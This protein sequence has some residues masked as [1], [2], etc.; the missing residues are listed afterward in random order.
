MPTTGLGLGRLHREHGTGGVGQPGPV[1]VLQ[2]L[3][4]RFEVPG[5][6]AF[7]GP[8]YYHFGLSAALPFFIAVENTLGSDPSF[9]ETCI[10]R[11]DVDPW[12]GH[13][14]VEGAEVTFDNP[15]RNPL[16]AATQRWSVSIRLPWG[17]RPPLADARFDSANGG[18]VLA[19]FLGDTW[20]EWD[21]QTNLS[22]PTKTSGGMD[23][24]PWYLAYANEDAAE[25]PDVTTVFLPDAGNAVFRSDWSSEA[26][27]G[28]LVA[29]HGDARKTL[30]DHVDGTSFTLAAYGEYLLLDPGYYKPNE[31]DNAIT[32]HG[33]AHNLILIDGQG[34]PNKGLLTD[35][36]D[37]DA[38][39][40]DFE[41]TD[42]LDYAEARIAY[43]GHDIVRGVALVRDSWFVI[44]DR[45]EG[46]GTHEYTFR[47]N[48]YAGH[49]DIGGAF[50]LNE[51]GA[52]WERTAAGVRVYVSAPGVVFQ[53]P[54]FNE[55]QRPHVH[56]F[57]N[58]DPRHHTVMDAVATG[59]AVDFLTVAVPYRVGDTPWTVTAIDGG[60]QV[61]DDTVTL[62]D[63]TLVITGP[64]G[65]LLRD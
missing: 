36:G 56:E 12:T 20:A 47:L 35:F 24:A 23:L 19:A 7:E 13:G 50:T 16:L 4:I 8:L 45:L 53:E 31:L 27:W 51:D 58:N 34:P 21:W 29:E 15:L 64:E 60:W 28:L 26:V 43:E 46:S 9:S 30:H 32:A 5:V 17:P 59:E 61:G 25:A 38:W 62:V 37:T 10:N 49:E 6:Q 57:E 39:L 65:E 44:A 33:D 22:A 41:Q 63:G 14:C 40:E 3:D 18:P 54:P 1:V 55:G 2:V 52:T 11:Q 42:A 48:G